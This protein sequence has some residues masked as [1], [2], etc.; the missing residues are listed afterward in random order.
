MIYVAVGYHVFHTRNMLKHM[1]VDGM[2]VDRSDSIPYSSSE[3]RYSSETVAHPL[4]T[5]EGD[6]IDCYPQNLTGRQEFYGTAVTEVQITREEPRHPTHHGVT[7]PAAAHTS[8]NPPRI[9]SWVLPGS[10]EQLERTTSGRGQRFETVCTSDSAPQP[11][12]TVIARLRSI[13]SNASLKLKRLDPVKMAYLRTSFIFGFAVLITWIPSSI[14]RLYSLTHH[15]RISFS[16]SVA[17]GCVLPLQGFWNTLIYFT[18]SWKIVREEART[19]KA[20][21][22]KRPE[23]CTDGIR[24]NSRLGTHKGDYRDTFERTRPVRAGSTEDAEKSM[25]E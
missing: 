9:Q 11:S 2:K 4:G 24:L 12:S 23:E 5:S 19:A 17:S 22:F 10:F 25:T 8:S 16:L 13:K 7:L 14:N 18:T 15:D 3:Q 21:W 20:V 6:D 1:V